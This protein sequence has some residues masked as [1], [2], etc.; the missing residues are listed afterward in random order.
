MKAYSKYYKIKEK[1][2]SSILNGKFGADGKLPTCRDLAKSFKVSYLTANKAVNLLQDEGYARMVQG[3]GNYAMIPKESNS[4]DVKQVGFIVPTV[5]HVFQT[6]F[7]TMVE[8][9]EKCNK[10]SIPFTP[11]RESDTRKLYEKESQIEKILSME[12]DSLVIDGRREFSFMHLEKHYKSKEQL[13]FI[14]RY[15]GEGKFPKSNKILTDYVQGGYLVASA[16]LKK[17]YN[18]IAL[19]TGKEMEVESAK[20]HG[21]RGSLIDQELEEGMSKAFNEKSLPNKKVIIHD[22][23]EKHTMNQLRD[24][25]SNGGNGVICMGDNRALPLYKL[26]DEMNLKIGKDIGVIGYYNTPWCESF[27][28]A[29]AS[30]SIEEE[31]IAEFALKS[32]KERWEN[33]NIIVP[34]KLIKR[35]SI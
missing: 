19:L 15:S 35:E 17:G 23:N 6:L 12:I 22:L 13:N 4:N 21:S 5:G 20:Q 24:F 28:P 26:A 30:V 8:G 9:V 34:P 3:S 18:N 10:V 14:I 1:L 2:K 31:K 7:S 32:I 16:L 29:L 27:S 25:I 33:K 11:P